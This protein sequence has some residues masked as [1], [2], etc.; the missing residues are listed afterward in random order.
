MKSENPNAVYYESLGIDHFL[1]H[2][3]TVQVGMCRVVDHPVYGLDAYPATLFTN[4]DRELLE[5][6]LAETVSEIF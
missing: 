1:K 2:M 4:A 6:V 5:R 3:K